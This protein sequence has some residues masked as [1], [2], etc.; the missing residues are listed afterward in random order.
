MGPLRAIIRDVVVSAEKSLGSTTSTRP[1][2]SGNSGSEMSI[3]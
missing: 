2:V 3:A 1:T